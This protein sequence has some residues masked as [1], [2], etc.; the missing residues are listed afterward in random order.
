MA[1]EVIRELS[2]KSKLVIT[3]GYEGNVVVLVPVD[4]LTGFCYRYKNHDRSHAL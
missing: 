4:K 2:E 3:Y 1:T